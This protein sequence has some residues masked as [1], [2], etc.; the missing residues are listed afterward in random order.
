VVVES[1]RKATRIVKTADMFKPA[2][3]V[4]L[5]FTHA[6]SERVELLKC[7]R[8]DA[9][10][11]MATVEWLPELPGSSP[12][13]LHP[14]QP[15]T[16]YYLREDLLCATE[17]RVER[18]DPTRPTLL[19]LAVDPETAAFKLRRYERLA[20]LGRLRLG[21][22]G[23]TGYFYYNDMPLPM[24][25]SLGGFGLRMSPQGWRSEDQIRFVLEA[26]IMEEDEEEPP[27]D[28]SAG[29]QASAEPGDIAAEEL[30]VLNLQG[31]AVLR[32]RIP[33]EG[34]SEHEYF[35]FEFVDLS[36]YQH[37]ELGL[38][39]ATANIRRREE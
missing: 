29:A 12:V 18:I 32:N 8:F 22:P 23:D 36:R 20:V 13:A 35:G 10:E 3:P 27:A 31:T 2:K 9:D 28:D 19:T 24:N 16:C 15:V 14:D 7:A 26:I 21:E 11:L 5:R 1:R 34:D 25:V 17:G 39:L 37:A 4:Y 6:D 30:P 33:I 38:W